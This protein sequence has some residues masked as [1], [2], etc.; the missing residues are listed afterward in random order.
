M[1]S[2]AGVVVGQAT[3]G[4]ASGQKVTPKWQKPVRCLKAPR[5]FESSACI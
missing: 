1:D 5:A 2:D 4:K 3:Y